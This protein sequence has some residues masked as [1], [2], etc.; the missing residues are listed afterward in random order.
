MNKQ[1]IVKELRKMSWTCANDK[2]VLDAAAELIET[3]AK[4]FED[5]VR[6][7]SLVDMKIGKLP[8]KPFQ[9]KL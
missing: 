8:M 1:D 3:Y 6:K 9:E 2:I 5:D 4:M 7:A